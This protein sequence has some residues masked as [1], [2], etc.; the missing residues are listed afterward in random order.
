[1][2]ESINNPDNEKIR[3][4][5]NMYFIALNIHINLVE[6]VKIHFNTYIHN[7]GG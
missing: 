6:T 4:F 1:M 3:I 7:K 2:V 5:E